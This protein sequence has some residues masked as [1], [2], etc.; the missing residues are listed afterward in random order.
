MLKVKVRL[1]ILLSHPFYLQI[2]NKTNVKALT[3]RAQLIRGAASPPERAELTWNS[4]G[5]V[6][7][8]GPAKQPLLTAPSAWR[9]HKTT[10]R[11]Q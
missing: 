6:L 7:Y 9:R 2:V 1:L 3:L 11:F 10:K 5:A 4:P 8:K